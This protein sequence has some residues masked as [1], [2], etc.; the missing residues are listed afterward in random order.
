MNIPAKTVGWTIALVMVLA[1][2]LRAH[3]QWLG[4]AVP[5]AL[6]MWYGLVAGARRN[7]N[8]VQQ[9]GRGGLH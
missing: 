8:A 2:A 4:M 6:L 5:G 9:R 7:T 3:L 1:L